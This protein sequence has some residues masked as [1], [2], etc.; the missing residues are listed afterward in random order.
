METTH[1]KK[2]LPY[3]WWWWRQWWWRWWTNSWLPAGES[4]TSLK[5]QNTI[6]CRDLRPLGQSHSRLQQ[7]R[8]SIGQIQKNAK[9]LRR[10]YFVFVRKTFPL[11]GFPNWRFW[12][13]KA[14]FWS[15]RVNLE[16]RPALR[17]INPQHRKLKRNPVATFAFS[18]SKSHVSLNW[19]P[20]DKN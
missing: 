20:C 5:P 16:L 8:K 1:F 17:I 10:C 4:E 18:N 12:N 19:N 3:L 7:I 2:G 9:S 11:Q 15:N 6:D 14:G 13:I